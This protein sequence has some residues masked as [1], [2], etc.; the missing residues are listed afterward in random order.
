[1]AEF[2]EHASE[3]TIH[4]TDVA[5]IETSLHAAAR[6]LADDPFG[7]ANLDA[8]EACR[9]LEEGFGGDDDAGRDDAADIFA[10]S[11][12]RIERRGRPKVHH[13]ARRA[14]TRNRRHAV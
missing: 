10:I 9:A 14:I 8:V 7:T 3:N 13:D 2:R 12:D 5:V 6:R 1:I 4:Q 11:V